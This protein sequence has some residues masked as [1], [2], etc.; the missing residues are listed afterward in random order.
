[1]RSTTL[2]LGGVDINTINFSSMEEVEQLNINTA[3]VHL[4]LP[5]G[6]QDLQIYGILENGERIQIVEDGLF[7]D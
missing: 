7:L 5:L 2:S 6:S 1:M 4:E 3:F